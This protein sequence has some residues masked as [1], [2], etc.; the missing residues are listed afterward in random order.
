MTVRSSLSSFFDLKGL[1]AIKVS[2]GPIHTS[3]AIK[4]SINLPAPAAAKY[5]AGNQ[6]KYKSAV[7]L[8]ANAKL[9]AIWMA[10]AFQ[11]F[12]ISFRGTYSV[13]A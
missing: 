7:T 9:I 8:V 12:I 13:M 6:T 5:G 4:M 2:N 11:R 10:A 1:T 3:A